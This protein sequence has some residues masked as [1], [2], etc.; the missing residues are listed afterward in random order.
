MKIKRIH[1][2]LLITV[3]ALTAQLSFA[4]PSA[5]DNQSLF[6]AA[7]TAKRANL[8]TTQNERWSRRCR[9]RCNQEYRLCLRGVAGP[10]AARCRARL[11]RC[12][13]RCY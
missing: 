11:R 9:R 8:T 1:S 7:A 12:L 3:L 13:R 5:V 4:A 10:N 2:A 6:Y